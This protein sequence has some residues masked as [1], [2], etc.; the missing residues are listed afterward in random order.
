[1]RTKNKFVVHSFPSLECIHDISAQFYLVLMEFG[2]GFAITA[3]VLVRRFHYICQQ[4]CSF[5]W[6][7]CCNICCLCML[8]TKK[9][10]S[11]QCQIDKYI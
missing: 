8:R 7:F 1:M 11:V 10:F 6:G 3:V 9:P 4:F 2:F 5:Y